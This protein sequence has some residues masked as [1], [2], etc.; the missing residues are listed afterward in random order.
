[1][2]EDNFSYWWD[3]VKSCGIHVPATIVIP[4]PEEMIKHFYMDNIMEDKAAIEQWCAD[5]AIKAID[6]SPLKGHLLFIKNATFSNKFDAFGS[7]MVA[8]MPSAGELASAL[9]NINYAA[10][11]VGADGCD[12]LVVRD[13]LDYDRSKTP[14]IYNGLPLR[15]EFRVFYDF[16][17]S[18]VLYTANY[19]DYDAVRP[20]LYDR[21]D[22]IIF[23]T[24]WPEIESAFSEKRVEAEAL[25]GEH[26]KNVRGLNGRWSVDL[27]LDGTTFWLIDMATAERSA[28]W[29]PLKCQSF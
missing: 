25:V 10:L 11:C 21:T 9:A 26:M 15:P 28:Y 16:D 24:I 6:A 27:L 2:N 7:C 23:D 22:K 14:C 5:T 17:T 12:E 1:M 3:K 19:W 29:D 18:Q 13:R 8:P 4:V 20:R